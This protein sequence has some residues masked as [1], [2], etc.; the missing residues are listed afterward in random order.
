MFSDVCPIVSFS[1]PA[2]TFLINIAPRAHGGHM[3]KIAVYG[4]GTIGSCQATLVIGHGI[5]CVVIGYSESGL[6]RCRKAIAQNWDDL[7]AEGLAT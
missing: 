6:E 2:Y 3:E 5:P 4:S 1:C 7:I